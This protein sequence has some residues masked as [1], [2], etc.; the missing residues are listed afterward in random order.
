MSDSIHDYNPDKKIKRLV[1]WLSFFEKESRNN[2]LRPFER[3]NSQIHHCKQYFQLLIE[4]I[5]KTKK[6]SP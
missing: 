3:E 5:T 4:E 1:H 6:N 2:L